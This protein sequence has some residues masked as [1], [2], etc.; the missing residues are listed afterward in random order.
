MGVIRKHQPNTSDWLRQSTNDAMSII[1]ERVVYLE[2][3]SPERNHGIRCTHC[4]NSVYDQSAT[5]QLE[6]NV[7][8]YCYGTTY[9]NGVYR[10]FYTNA[11]VG[12]ARNQDSFNDKK[13]YSTSLSRSAKMLWPA[14]PY[15]DDFLIRIFEWKEVEG[16]KVSPS[17]WRAYRVTSD[18]VV[19]SLQDGF[20]PAATSPSTIGSTFTIHEQDDDHP[21][22]K[23]GLVPLDADLVKSTQPF[24]YI[25]DHVTERTRLSVSNN[26]YK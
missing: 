4:F 12:K 11:I 22:N 21:M 3:F 8:P 6:G 24:I 14:K 7:C 16:N 26:I 5:S 18:I 2:M 20:N 25:P 9:Q 15:K 23:Q 17:R 19:G 1:G 13:G 10:L